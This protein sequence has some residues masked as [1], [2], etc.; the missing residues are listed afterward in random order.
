MVPGQWH[1]YLI[2]A[3]KDEVG[4]NRQKVLL[5]AETPQTEGSRGVPHLQRAISTKNKRKQHQL[6]QEGRVL[7]GY[8]P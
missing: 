6:D 3:V 4:E 8:S 2:E 7:P 1:E 5:L